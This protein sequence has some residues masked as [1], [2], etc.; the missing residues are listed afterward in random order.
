[1]L[2]RIKKHQDI[3]QGKWNGLGGKFLP[4]ETPEEC[5]RREVEEES[6]LCVEN[7]RLR[8][9]LTFPC[10]D[11]VRDWYVFVF[12][13]EKFSGI[14]RESPEGVLEWIATERLPELEL[15]EGD[16]LFLPWLGRPEMFSAQF[17]YVEGRLRSH[18]VNFY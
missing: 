12:L 6:G 14:E 7:P 1:M 13:A 16:R 8:G 10:F 2:H 4:G 9:V 15:W 3:H 18:V 5:V 11:G 17:S